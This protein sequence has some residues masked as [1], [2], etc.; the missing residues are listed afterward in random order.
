MGGAFFLNGSFA[1]QIIKIKH[2]TKLSNR[3]CPIAKIG[4]KLYRI[5]LVWGSVGR[6]FRGVWGGLKSTIGVFPKRIITYK[7]STQFFK[8]CEK[9]TCKIST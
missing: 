6:A 2:H 9:P 7:I 1:K 5:A 3:N 4:P 8:E